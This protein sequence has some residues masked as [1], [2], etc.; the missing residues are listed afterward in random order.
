[1][2]ITTFKYLQHLPL[3]PHISLSLSLYPSLSLKKKQCLEEVETPIN[4]GDDCHGNKVKQPIR[5]SYVMNDPVGLQILI[6]CSVECDQLRP[7]FRSIR[8]IQR[9]PESNFLKACYLCNKSLSLNKDV[10]MYR[11]DLGFCSVECR[12]RQIY[13]DEM[14]EI[15]ASTKE[16]SAS[17]RHYE[18]SEWVK[19][20][21]RVYVPAAA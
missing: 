3:V 8:P 6:Q 15:E 5:K 9:T 21:R 17:Y 2:L 14:K 18:T 1:M 20:A 12:C 19:S 4:F 7:V 13:L 16:F 10:Y 11:G